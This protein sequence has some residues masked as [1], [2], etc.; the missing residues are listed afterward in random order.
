MYI[1]KIKY[2]YK[3]INNLIIIPYKFR[4]FLKLNLK[5]SILKYIK[6]L[7]HYLNFYYF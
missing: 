6:T 3:K 1:I 7:N 5:N 4:L 2:K